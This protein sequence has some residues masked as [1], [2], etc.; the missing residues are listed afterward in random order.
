MFDSDSLCRILFEDLELPADAG[1][2]VA[3]SGGCDSLVLLHALSAARQKF[4]FTLTALHF[5]HGLLP[6]S[7]DW[8]RQCEAVCREWGIAFMRER[9]AVV[10]QP[11][12]SLEALARQSRYRWF[13]Q[14]VAPGQVLLTAHHANDQ[15][16]TVLLNL[17]RGGGVEA[18]AGIPQR[19]TLSAATHFS[20]TRLPDTRSSEACSS[21]TRLPEAQATLVARPLLSF[22]RKALREYARRHGLSWIEDPSNQSPEFDRNYLRN[23]I[24]PL[25]EKRWPGAVGSLGS[26]AE[27][28][29]DA[30]GFLDEIA[31]ELFTHCRADEKTG[32]FCLAPP[33]NVRSLKQPGHFQA[34]SLIRHWLHRHGRRSPSSGQLATLYEQVFEAESESAGLRWDDLEL[35]YFDGHIYLTPQLDNSAHETIEWDLQNCD[36]EIN[37]LR[38]VV[39]NTTSGDLDPKKLRGKSVKWMWRTGGERMTLPGRNHSSALK[40][41]LQQNAAPPWERNALPLLVVDGE[42]AWAHRV[43]PGAACCHD[44]N[45]ADAQAISLRFVAGDKR[46]F[47]LPEP[48]DPPVRR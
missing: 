32:V 5:D 38:V 29:R 9:Q 21:D 22:P 2:A 16:E 43:G 34:I 44:K 15:A 25:L 13:E 7:A 28:C 20:A 24:I 47:R 40:K 35:R 12:E 18:L 48:V 11:G 27:N 10:K 41:L 4:G 6:Q 26:S 39:S 36:L 17:L 8:A 45:N 33:L 46:E 1:F 30:A 31:Q 19:R 37:G 14:V 42:V 3:Y 23:S